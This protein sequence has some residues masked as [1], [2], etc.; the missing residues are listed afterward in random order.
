MKE[1]YFEDFRVG[2]KF[3]TKEKSLSTEEIIKFAE[4]YDPQPFHM[5]ES[6]AAESP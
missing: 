1:K 3:H 2:E 5:D 6:A 4:L